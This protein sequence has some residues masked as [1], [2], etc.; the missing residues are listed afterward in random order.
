MPWDTTDIE[1][2]D[3]KAF[4]FSNAATRKRNEIRRFPIKDDSASAIVGTMSYG[5]V[6]GSSAFPELGIYAGGITKTVF[7]WEAASYSH[8]GGGDL[9]K[10][11][12]S[13]YETCAI[14]E[15]EVFVL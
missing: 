7:V 13:I 14:S 6:F 1:R 15:Y 4:L 8:E 3:G 9:I 5:P 12:G 11:G 2:P 10:F